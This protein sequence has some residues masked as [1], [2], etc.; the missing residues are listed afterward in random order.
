MR[1]SDR[2][3]FPAGRAQLTGKSKITLSGPYLGPHALPCLATTVPLQSPSRARVQ[4]TFR[5][6]A[7]GALLSTWELQPKGGSGGRRTADVMRVGPQSHKAPRRRAGRALTQPLA[8][9][10]N[11]GRQGRA[12]QVKP[13]R[14]GRVCADTAVHS[15]GEARKAGPG[16]C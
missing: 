2:S 1:A 11:P 3:M 5:R 6:V 9:Q 15:P 13:G 14:Q 4:G 10:V 12:L 8:L 7:S 16:V